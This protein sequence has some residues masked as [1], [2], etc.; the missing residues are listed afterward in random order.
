MN[1]EPYV[2]ASGRGHRQ[3]GDADGARRPQGDLSLRL[4]GRRRRQHRRGD[5]SRPEPLSGQRRAGTLPPHQ[6]HPAARRPDRARR[7]RRQ[8]RLVP[9]HRRRR[10]GR[11]RRTAQQL[12]DHE[13]LHRS[14][15]RGRPLR[16][17]ARFGK[18]VRPHG[19]QG[20]DP[21]QR[22]H[23]QPRRRAP[24]RRRLRHLDPGVRAHR[25]GISEA[26]HLGRR[27]ARPARSS[28][29]TAARRKAST[30]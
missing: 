26:D 16:R 20:P 4:A 6:P 15:R 7:G 25:R 19:R 1:E 11:L 18:E 24:R 10:R 23:P 8:A 22:P 29:P 12:R 13:G 28:C 14:R 30:T 2:N 21:D 9:A 5:V 17:P 27:R 3:P